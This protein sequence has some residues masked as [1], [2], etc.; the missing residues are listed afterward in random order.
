MTQP[1]RPRQ[2]SVR[3]WVP[4]QRPR[5][6]FDTARTNEL[7]P[8]SHRVAVRTLSQPD[9]TGEID[10][11]DILV[12]VPVARPP[13]RRVSAPPPP[14]DEIVVE[15]GPV[16]VRPPTFSI[17]ATQEILAE[18]VVEELALQQAPNPFLE[19]A[20]FRP[21]PY[22]AA[23]PSDMP[24]APP[25]P[26]TVDTLEED[27]F[28]PHLSIRD[29]QLTALSTMELIRRRSRG[30]LVVGAVV[31]AAVGVVLLALGIK[32]LSGGSDTVSA[33][34]EPATTLVRDAKTREHLI[35][36]PAVNVGHAV[37]PTRH[38]AARPA[39]TIDTSNV[40]T[41]SID[42]LPRAR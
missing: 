33:A 42:S 14:A 8:L 7:P 4:V 18:D 39:L 27:L 15:V 2:H 40:P 31:G 16:E 3:K 20:P 35:Y 23:P 25:P 28:A 13:A 17:N 1:P 24:S 5:D 29:P 41:V 38:A 11:A 34:S 30:T 9:T 26:W 22:V 10:A 37:T 19:Q 36:P 6:D 12:A 32:L 21:A